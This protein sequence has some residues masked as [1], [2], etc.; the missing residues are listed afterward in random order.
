MSGAYSG[1]PY[2]ASAGTTVNFNQHSDDFEKAYGVGGHAHDATL[3]ETTGP[4]HYSGGGTFTKAAQAGAGMSAMVGRAEQQQFGDS[5]G[6]GGIEAQMGKMNLGGGRHYGQGKP[7]KPQKVYQQQDSQ[8]DS[9]EEEEVEE[10]DAD[11]EEVD[12]EAEEEEDK[13]EEAEEEEE[14]EEEEE[15]EEEEEEEEEEGSDDDDDSN[16]ESGE[17]S[18]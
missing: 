11:D 4:T 2:G 7:N 8:G 10:E 3:Y 16:S 18:E 15:G 14:Q 6:D 17:D 9:E 1:G 13:E 5:R 12:E